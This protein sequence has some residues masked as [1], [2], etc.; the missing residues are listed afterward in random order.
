LNSQ[1]PPTQSSTPY[2]VAIV[3]MLGAM[4]GLI[5]WKTSRHEAA[6]VPVQARPAALL[7]APP[8]LEAP[9]PP[10]PPPPEEPASV[11]ANAV[12]QPKKGAAAPAGSSAAGCTGTESSAMRGQLAGLGRTARRCY[13]DALAKNA[14]LKGR[15]V[16]SVRVGPSGQVTSATIAS[17]ETG[18][19]ALASCVAQKFRT[20]QL[21]APLG[22]CVDAQVPLNFVPDNAR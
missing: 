13:Y 6:E 16:V 4:G 3:V 14:D 2:V 21:S 20:A 5:L 18:D 17:N 7:E 11:A 1:P 8:V 15:V 9:A 12:S 19:A 22:G 10:P